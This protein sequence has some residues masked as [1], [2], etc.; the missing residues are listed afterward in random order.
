MESNPIDKLCMI[1]GATSGIGKATAKE[2]ACR[3]FNII[4]VCRN[5]EKSDIVRN[6]IIDYSK[7]DNVDLLIADF[8]S[9]DA[10]R[11]VIRQFKQRYK[12][13]HVLINNAGTFNY[14]RE[15]TIDGYESTFA[16]DYL[17]HFLLTNLL[18]DTLKKSAPARIINVSSNIHKYFKTYHETV[19][20]DNKEFII[21]MKAN[22]FPE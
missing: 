17:A 3:G 6:E 13:L 18:L 2:L 7:N 21:K 9:L 8:S 16:I 11:K 15:L 5:K 20:P 12:K 4:M 1:T 10:V 22:M 14:S 19:Q